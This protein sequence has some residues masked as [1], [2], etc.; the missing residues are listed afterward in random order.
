MN[1]TKSSIKQELAY[2]LGL[3]G[4]II[5]DDDL[6]AFAILKILKSVCRSTSRKDTDDRKE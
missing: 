6:I 5:I 2:Y 1:I 3:E 4:K